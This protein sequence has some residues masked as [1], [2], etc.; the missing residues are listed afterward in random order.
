M[1]KQVL[2]Y[3]LIMVVLTAAVLSGCNDDNAKVNNSTTKTSTQ[4]TNSQTQSNS[5]STSTQSTQA[6][7]DVR[8]YAANGDYRSPAG[9]EDYN[10]S[11]TTDKNGVVID[12]NATSSTSNERSSEFQSLFLDGIKTQVI[13]KPLKDLG[14]VDRVNGASLT[15]IGYNKALEQIKSQAKVS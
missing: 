1:R 7:A 5:A 14:A 4:Q 8:V 10:V 15:P 9:M 3:W 13:G 2:F 11:I 12:I 6:N